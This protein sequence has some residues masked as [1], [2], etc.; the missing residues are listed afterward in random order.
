MGS[1]FRRRSEASQTLGESL[2]GPLIH[3]L[4][5]RRQVRGAAGQ[6]PSGPVL[7][8]PDEAKDRQHIPGLDGGPRVGVPSR[9]P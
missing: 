9:R 8:V 1:P 3:P 7:A 6:P 4:D 2:W 5:Q